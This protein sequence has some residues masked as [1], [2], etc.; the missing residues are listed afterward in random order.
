[1]ITLGSLFA[2]KGKRP[3][4]VT[5]AAHIWRGEITSEHSKIMSDLPRI[6]RYWVT[7]GLNAVMLRAVAA[8]GD[9]SNFAR[10]HGFQIRNA[11]I[12]DYGELGGSDENQ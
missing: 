2:G 10:S 11:A 3:L 7:A 1:M 12:G 4:G 6:G 9:K 5:E 8:V